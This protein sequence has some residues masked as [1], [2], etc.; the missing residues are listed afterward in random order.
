MT[1]QKR[2]GPLAG[3]P[4]AM[5]TEQ[6][7]PNRTPSESL[8]QWIVV[9]DGRRRSMLWNK[10]RSEPEAAEQVRLLLKQGLAARIIEGWQS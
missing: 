5:R 4:R 6:D 7:S 9:I 10:Y 2:H 1:L 3:D 8:P